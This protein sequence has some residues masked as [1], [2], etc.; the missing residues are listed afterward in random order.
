M[1]VS[2]LGY[3]GVGVSDTG[4]WERFAEQVLGMQVGERREDGIVYLRMDEYHHRVILHPSGEDDILYTGF[5]A[6]TRGEYEEAKAALRRLGASVVQGTKEE[7]DVRRVVDF[8]HFE[9]GGLRFELSFGPAIV[10][11]SPFKP[12]RALSGFKT[13]ELGM[14]HI[15][16]RP[17]EVEPTVKLLMEALGFRLSDYVFTMTF[18]HCNPRHHTVALQQH[19]PS[20]P[21][22]ANK[23]MWHFMLETDTLD[24]VGLAFDAA[25]NTETPPATTIG[26]HMNDHM[27]SFYV[28]T[29]SGFEIEYGWNGRLIDDSTWQVVRHVSGDIWGHKRM[30]P[31]QAAPPAAAAAPAAAASR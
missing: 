26:K 24:D 1:A 8:V 17:N 6:S 27:V 15:V 4:A 25:T 29:P 11:A 16:L 14:G 12:G 23:R 22:P 13:G 30:R 2:Q 3:I 9:S 5:Q 21:S 19:N 20:L 10:Y 31:Q 18:L 7:I 28:T